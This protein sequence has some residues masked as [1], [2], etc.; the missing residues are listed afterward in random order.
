LTSV[1]WPVAVPSA[2][3]RALNE[4]LRSALSL[5]EPEALPLDWASAGAAT[6][7]AAAERRRLMRMIGIPD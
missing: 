1:A 5:P 3:I 4:K 6:S 2:L 7:K